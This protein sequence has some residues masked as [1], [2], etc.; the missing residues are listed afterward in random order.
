ML[1]YWSVHYTS[2]VGFDF[3]FLGSGRRIYPLLL[4]CAG[5]SRFV[6]CAYSLLHHTKLSVAQVAW[7]LPPSRK[8]T[9]WLRFRLQKLAFPQYRLFVWRHMRHVRL[10]QGRNLIPLSFD[11]SLYST[12][13][14]ILFSYI[15]GKFPRFEY[16]SSVEKIHF[17]YEF[18]SNDVIQT[19]LKLHI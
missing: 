19:H 11:C 10:P 13:R 2:F 8:R 5:S 3:F 1:C 18:W 17:S 14:S 9:A 6:L 7:L 16:L 4:W 12:D 15:I